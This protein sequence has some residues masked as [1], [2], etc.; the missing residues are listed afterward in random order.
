MSTDVLERT[1]PPE[2]E[3]G[4]LAHIVLPASGVTEAYILG[5]PVEA[6]C[7]HVFVP[8]R[9]PK[10]LPV[11]PACKEILESLGHNLEGHT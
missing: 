3:H 2:L 4:P 10:P 5:T 8:T 11:C 1:A 9:D 7:G 6:L